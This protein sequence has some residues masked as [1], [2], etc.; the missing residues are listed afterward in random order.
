LHVM[1]FSLAEYVMCSRLF[2]L[3]HLQYPD[4]CSD[5]ENVEDIPGDFQEFLV[6]IVFIQM[7]VE[8]FCPLRELII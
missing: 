3:L 5:W 2:I 1:L 7:P 8:A 4:C 6:C